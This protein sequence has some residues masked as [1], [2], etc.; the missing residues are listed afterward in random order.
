MRTAVAAIGPPATFVGRRDEI[1]AL[2]GFSDDAWRGRLR[3]VVVTGDAGIGKSALLDQLLAEWRAGGALVR[4]AACYEDVSVPYL[5]LISALRDTTA[6]DRAADRGH[7]G[8]VLTLTDRAPEL[9]VGLTDRLLDAAA[10]TR[11]A[12]R[13]DDVHWAD[14]ATLDLLA[15]LLSTAARRAA[16]EPITLLV[17]LSTRPVRSDVPAGRLLGRL[18]REVSHRSVHVGPLDEI[19]VNLLLEALLPVRPSRRLLDDVIEITEGNP[20][21]VRT[22]VEHLSEG[23]R[24]AVDHGVMVARGEV[25]AEPTDLD[26]VLRRR[27]DRLGER[28]RRLVTTAALMGSGEHLDVLAHVVAPTEIDDTL[29][30]RPSPDASMFDTDLDDVEAAGLLVEQP[31]GTYAFQHPLVR[32]LLTRV[33]SVRSRRAVHLHIAQRLMVLDDGHDR[34]LQIAHHLRRAGPLAPT[35]EVLE[36]A[37]QATDRSVEVGAWAKAQRYAQLALDTLELTADSD[38]HRRV[39]TELHLQAAQAHFRNHDAE[40]VEEHCAAAIALARESDDVDSWGRALLVS[41]RNRLTLGTEV[42]AD[43]SR[44]HELRSFLDTVGDR[45]PHVRARCWQLLAEIEFTAGDLV[46]AAD[47]AGRA[48]ELAARLGD[49]T[50]I[51]E[52]LFAEGLEQFGSLELDAA[53]ESF[54]ASAASARAGRAEW[55]LAW[56]LGRLSLVHLLRGDVAAARAAASTAEDLG[57]RTHHWAEHGLATAAAGLA[58]LAAGDLATAERAAA[59]ADELHARSSYPFIVSIAA[60]AGAYVRALRLDHL[61]ALEA[62]DRWRETGVA[63]AARFRLL[64]DA[65]TLPIA[66]LSSSVDLHRYRPAATLPLHAFL[67]GGLAVDVELGVRLG[68]DELLSAALP[69]LDDLAGRGVRLVIPTAAS[70][71]RL[72]GMCLVGLGDVDRGVTLLDAA[73]RDL[74][75]AGAHLEATRCR[76]ERC[77]AMASVDE[78]GAAPLA[79]AL[80]REL[81]EASLLAMAERLREALPLSLAVSARLRRTVVAWDM[82]GSTLLLVAQGDDGFVDVL[83]ELNDVIRRR[84]AEHG[85]VEF[86]HTGDGIFAWFLDA[87]DAMRCAAEV[88][89]DLR[90]RNRRLSTQPVVLRT[91]L[92]VG[93]PVDD[94]GDLFGLAVVTASRL[95][96]AAGDDEIWCTAEVAARADGRVA[97]RSVGEVSL[98]GIP[99]PV[100]VVAIDG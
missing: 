11:I 100:P 32:Q 18:R 4:S 73:E 59:E 53:V 97:T 31:D 47:A 85:G 27:V 66:E 14:Q 65:T 75:S 70:V 45:A 29:G 3:I 30:T 33:P 82:V 19:A 86:K 48:R 7:M 89:D 93:E 6:A 5:P 34:V 50:L 26:A 81:D 21:F 13:I 99:R 83:H 23:G 98:K 77:I 92:A 69:R 67:V 28:A 72:R 46:A 96:A 43:R 52:V 12:L 91:G 16:L 9:F 51:A 87:G 57:K 15:H 56:P 54:E 95:C 24:L 25:T 68:R 38:E 78:A 62:L 49:D 20:L 94:A 88:R 80:V 44:Y 10:T 55:V 63:G 64:V 22:L 41:H 37:R 2:R 61:G 74:T 8:D 58:A 90:Y 35:D 39:A 17:A 84:L 40:A 36:Y 42:V 79:R 71:D 1:E 76:V 60:P